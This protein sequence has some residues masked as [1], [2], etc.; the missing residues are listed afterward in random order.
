MIIVS[1]PAAV[2]SAKTILPSDGIEIDK[3]GTIAF[4]I[5]LIPL[6]VRLATP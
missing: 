1:F 5:A 4:P 6:L 3:F 2:V